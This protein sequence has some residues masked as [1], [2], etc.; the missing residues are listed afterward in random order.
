MADYEQER[1][2]GVEAVTRACRLCQLVQSQLVTSETVIKADRSP[3]TAADFGSQA[4][5]SLALRDAFP[6]DPIVAE[7][8]AD[9]LLELGDETLT[10]RII[11]YV[12]SVHGRVEREEILAA[13]GRGTHPGGAQGRFW[14]IDPIDGTKGFLRQEQYAVSLAL[15]ENGQVVLGIL[16]C[17]NYPLN[18][19]ESEA[20]CG[21]LFVAARG[22]GAV[23]RGL[24][25]GRE[26]PILVSDTEDPAEVVVCES[27]EAAHSSHED[28]RKIIERLGVEIPPLR[29]DSQCKYAAVAR[30]DASIY[31][32]LP[33]R[34]DYR[35]KIWDHAAGWIVLKE[36]GGEI[37][38]LNGDPIDFTPG[39]LLSANTGIV[40]TNGRIH[41][42]VLDAV[43]A[44]LGLP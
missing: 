36:A 39:R 24:E 43:Q 6:G 37:T 2:F 4:A 32:R 25:D 29:M 13:L 22:Q 8:S 5:I 11:H 30:A 16:G 1:R 34:A 41:A 28:A 27:V 10:E 38:G 31:L 33:T 20:D 12:Q 21:Y 44:V 26:K 42:R 15:V 3:V 40:A 23:M 9:D 18:W 35:E 19:L 17:P 7:E 14:T